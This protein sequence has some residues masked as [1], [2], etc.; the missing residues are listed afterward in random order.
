MKKIKQAI[1]N[2]YLP[3][4]EKG[5]AEYTSE[6]LSEC[7]DIYEI[8]KA[9]RNS[10]KMLQYIEERGNGIKEIWIEKG[11]IMVEIEF[12]SLQTVERLELSEALSKYQLYCEI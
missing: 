1:S 10:L 9:E 4:I 6:E 5:K 2:H 12:K 3:K 8:I 11:D 7:S